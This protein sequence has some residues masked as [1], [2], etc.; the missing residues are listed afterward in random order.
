ML[1]KISGLIVV[2]LSFTVACVTA[3][4]PVASEVKKIPQPSD[5]SL[6]EAAWKA[7]WE[8]VLKGARKE[9]RIVLYGAPVAEVRSGFMETFQKSYPGIELVY[10]GLTGR[11]AAPKLAAE[12][13][14]GLYLVDVH[15][16]GTTT[17]LTA[18]KDFIKPIKPFLILPTVTDPKSWIGG[19][20]D[21]SDKAEEL[22]LVFNISVKSGVAYNTELVKPGEINSFWDLAKPNF[23][24][25]ILMQDP[26]V[27]GGGLAL[28]TFWYVNKETGLD[29]IRALAANQPALS[30]DKRYLVEALARGKYYITIGSGT[31]EVFEF[32]GLGMPV[33]YVPILK[34][35]T[36]SSAAT[37]SVAVMDRAPNP[38]AAAVFL[39]W[40]LSKEG[41]TVWTIATGFPSRRLDA[42][43]GHIDEALRPN[44]RDLRLYVP[45]DK[46]AFVN[47]RDEL[48]PHLEQ[49]FR[50]F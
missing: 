13:R 40:L 8:S 25:K 23:K 49:I 26:R 48:V 43:T 27:S 37:G 20:L 3:G 36:Y 50:G 45:T 4:V 47:M 22:N 5:I 14:A 24:G 33:K 41:Q 38:N 11:E 16:G 35:G 17:M 21:F 44:V 2:L 12:R 42:P 46:E 31:A 28:A 34:E 6:P 32:M 7:K 10:T 29:F 15:I 9:G 39:N 19:K 30:R 1:T 18:L